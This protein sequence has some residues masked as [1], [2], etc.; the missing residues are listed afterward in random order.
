LNFEGTLTTASAHIITAVVGSGILSLAWAI[1]Q[2]GW[3]AGVFTL[4][5]FSII[6]L[7]TSA[8]LANCYRSPDPITG[9][10]NY[11]YI[12]AV[13]SNL[14]KK[15]M[16]F[17]FFQL[18]LLFFRLFFLDIRGFAPI[19]FSR[20]HAKRSLHMNRVK[21]GF[22]YAAVIPNNCLHSIGLIS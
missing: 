14:G 15:K 2:L 6:T 12:E 10:R 3:I 20:Y 11:T 18:L 5:I 17:F 9:R 16:A 22:S 13:K 7:Y 4:V 21:V 8:L 1:A 19:R